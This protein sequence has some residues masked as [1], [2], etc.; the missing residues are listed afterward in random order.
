[1]DSPGE[2]FGYILSLRPTAS[3]SISPYG[4]FKR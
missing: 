1:M 4:G 2:A 3:K